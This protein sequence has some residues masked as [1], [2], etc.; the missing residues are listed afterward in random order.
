MGKLPRA[1]QSKRR[2]MRIV[3]NHCDNQGKEF[4]PFSVYRRLTKEKQESI[5]RAR[6]QSRSRESRIAIVHPVQ[7]NV[8]ADPVDT[9]AINDSSALHQSNVAEVSNVSEYAPARAESHSVATANFSSGSGG[10]LLSA[11][12]TPAYR[13]KSEIH[14][15]SREHANSA[16]EL[17]D[18]LANTTRSQKV[19]CVISPPL[20]YN[21][22]SNNWSINEHQPVDFNRHRRALTPE[23]QADRQRALHAL[24][25]M[26]P[27]YPQ[28][29]RG[30]GQFQD[31]YYLVVQIADT[32]LIGLSSL[33]PCP[34]PSEWMFCSDN[35]L[36]ILPPCRRRFEEQTRRKY[37]LRI[38]RRDLCV[39]LSQNRR[40]RQRH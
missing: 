13:V 10:R 12:G 9:N 23:E 37:Y 29:I 17:G 18:I 11:H 22:E 30:Q 7:R 14:L 8:V 40:S 33:Q 38:G 28:W 21:P 16:Q 27:P 4:V 19:P 31:F 24:M 36:D 6:L 1:S 15:P 20:Y 34:E 32:N 3:R 2:R 5:A 39:R 25:N 26:T 35:D